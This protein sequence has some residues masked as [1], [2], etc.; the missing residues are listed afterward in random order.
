MGADHSTAAFAALA[1]LASS[2]V[3]GRAAACSDDF[4]APMANLVNPAAAIFVPGQFTSRGK[5]MDGWESAAQA[6]ARPRLVRR[7][8]RDPRQ[9]RRRQRRYQPL[10]RQPAVVLHDRC[11]RSRGTGDDGPL[12][13]SRLAVDAYSGGGAA[14][15][16]LAQLLRRRR[17][18]AVDARA[19]QHLS[20]RRR[21]QAA[22]IRRR[23][24]STGTP[25]PGAAA[26]SI[27]R[28][29]ATAAWFSA[30]AT[31]TSARATT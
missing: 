21:R 25:S 30:P 2:R 31:C 20:G 14:G 26:S 28:Q 17:R 22:G 19:A 15:A 11:A 27:S 8:A 23:P 18:P 24:R 4:F 9:C 12:A 10:H 29:S 16:K 3:G 6:D 5:W 7:R 1:D 13:A